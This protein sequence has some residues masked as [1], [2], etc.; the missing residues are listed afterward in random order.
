MHAHAMQYGDESCILSGLTYTRIHTH[1]RSLSLARNYPEIWRDCAM[2]GAELIIRPQ[3]VRV[4]V[5]C[6]QFQLLL[7]DLI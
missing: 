3:G 4:P 1:T 6:S 2:R 5:L 7:L